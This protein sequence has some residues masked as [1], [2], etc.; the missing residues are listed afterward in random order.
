MTK[1]D[2]IEIQNAVECKIAFLYYVTSEGER[3]AYLITEM[4]MSNKEAKKAIR[5]RILSIAKHN[6]L[7]KADKPTLFDPNLIVPSDF[8]RHVKNKIDILDLWITD[9]HPDREVTVT[10]V[11]FPDIPLGIFSMEDYID[12][13]K[14]YDT[15]CAALT[16]MNWLDQPR[17]IFFLKSDLDEETSRETTRELLMDALVDGYDLRL[18]D[19]MNITPPDFLLNAKIVYEH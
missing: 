14:E 12:F 10:K 11:G 19:P 17:R 13:Q 8:R 16:Y 5:S 9:M 6:K 2:F 7:I 3:A 18:F 15:D 4:G 1:E